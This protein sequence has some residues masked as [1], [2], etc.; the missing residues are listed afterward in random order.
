MGTGTEILAQSLQIHSSRIASL[1]V[2]LLIY[3]QSTK[4]LQVIRP[5]AME[6]SQMAGLLQTYSPPH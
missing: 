3:E 2:P 1:C 4:Q 6:A 5:D